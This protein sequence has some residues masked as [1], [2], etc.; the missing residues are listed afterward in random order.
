MDRRGWDGLMGWGGWMDRWVTCVHWWVYGTDGWDGRDRW[1]SG[2][3]GS[4]GG[5]MCN[6]G[7]GVWVT[8]WEGWVVCVALAEGWV[9]N[10]GKLCGWTGG[11]LDGGM[12]KYVAG[13]VAG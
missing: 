11:W 5:W 13:C 9:G 7:V 6:V 2:V 4:V 1:I 12:V 3:D 8:L 10:I